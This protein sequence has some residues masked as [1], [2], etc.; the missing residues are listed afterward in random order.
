MARHVLLMLSSQQPPPPLEELQWHATQC[1]VG[2]GTAVATTRVLS[3]LAPGRSIV[4]F[5]GDAALGNRYL[6]KGIYQGYV[7][8][9]TSQGRE[10]WRETPLY[11]QRGVPDGMKGFVLLRGVEVAGEDDTL[12]TLGGTIEATDLPLTV[13]NLPRSAARIQVYFR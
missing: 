13:N 10:L 6:G 7:P 1:R 3:G 12:D 5:Y 9:H 8:S 11:Q 2:G 4:A